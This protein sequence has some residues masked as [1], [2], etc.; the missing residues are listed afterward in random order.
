M[1]RTCAAIAPAGLTLALADEDRHKSDPGPVID[2]HGLV[3]HEFGHAVACGSAHI[4]GDDG[5]GVH[6]AAPGSRQTGHATDQGIHH[7]GRGPA[8]LGFR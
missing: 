2:V 4:P 6:R 8:A 3:M 1:R 5:A 7:R